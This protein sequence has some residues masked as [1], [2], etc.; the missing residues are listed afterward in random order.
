M[1]QIAIPPLSLVN[2]YSHK[3]VAVSFFTH[4]KIPFCAWQ[5]PVD[6]IFKVPLFFKF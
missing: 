6:S 4:T 1:G 3:L 5:Y 2:I